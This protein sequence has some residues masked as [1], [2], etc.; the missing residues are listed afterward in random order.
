MV[1][2]ENLPASHEDHSQNRP[3]EKVGKAIGVPF[4]A[5]CSFPCTCGFAG[6]SISL[7]PPYPLTSHEGGSDVEEGEGCA[8]SDPALRSPPEFFRLTIG[9]DV[10]T[11]PPLASQN[12]GFAWQPTKS[13]EIPLRS[14]RLLIPRRSICIIQSISGKKKQAQKWSTLFLGPKHPWEKLRFGRSVRVSVGQQR[15]SFGLSCSDTDRRKRRLFFPLKRG[16]MQTKKERIN[17]DK[18][19]NLTGTGSSLRR[20]YSRWTK[21]YVGETRPMERYTGIAQ[22]G[23]ETHAHAK[24]AKDPPLEVAAFGFLAFACLG[25]VLPLETPWAHFASCWHATF[26]RPGEREECGQ[27]SG[28]LKARSDSRGL[29]HADLREVV[30]ATAGAVIYGKAYRTPPSEVWVLYW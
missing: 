22:S 28:R 20:F 10:A 12:A 18:G 9:E 23:I 1:A 14:L 21:K 17:T 2:V 26:S 30:F 27:F 24:R 25:A 6:S 11:W 5:I 16:I 13:T 19:A 4:T 8:D 3:P 7:G 15:R 29:F